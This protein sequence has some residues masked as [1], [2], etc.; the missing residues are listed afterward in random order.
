[1]SGLV[2]N[3][4][5]FATRLQSKARMNI[6]KAIFNKKKKE[7]ASLKLQSI[8]RMNIAKAIFNKKKEENASLKLQSIARIYIAKKC[9]IKKITEKIIFT[10]EADKGIAEKK[11]KNI[12]MIKT[13]NSRFKSINNGRLD[14]S[15]C[16][17]TDDFFINN[18]V[19][20]LFHYDNITCL[21]LSENQITDTGVRS[22][23]KILN[24]KKYEFQILALK[25]T[26]L[27]IAGPK[28]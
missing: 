24:T 17:I 20:R 25:T 21:D 6:A 14:L 8:A 26:E 22:I 2:K 28:K 18:I 12:E 4:D 7:N 23:V 16:E 3:G 10:F 13:L 9:I 15:S 5:Y 19:P 1:M 11:Y 27:Q